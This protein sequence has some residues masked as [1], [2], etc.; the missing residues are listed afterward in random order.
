MS[1]GINTD[2]INRRKKTLSVHKIVVYRGKEEVSQ[3]QQF[4]HI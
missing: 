2:N 1:F 3:E 4:A